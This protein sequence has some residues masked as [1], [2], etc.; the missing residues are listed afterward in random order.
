[1]NPRDA[2]GHRYD[3]GTQDNTLAFLREPSIHFVTSWLLPRVPLESLSVVVC[4][5]LCQ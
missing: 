1:M 5:T 2:I 4:V 3:K